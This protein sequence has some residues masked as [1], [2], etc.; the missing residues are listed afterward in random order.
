MLGSVVVDHI[1]SS[2]A[3]FHM[4]LWRD[5]EVSVDAHGVEFNEPQRVIRW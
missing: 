1:A 5:F 4:P 3:R 2:M